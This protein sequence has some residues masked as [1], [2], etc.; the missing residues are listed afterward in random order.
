MPQGTDVVPPRL[1]WSFDGRCLYVKFAT[2]TYAIP[3]KPGQM[4]PPVPASG[5]A[6]KDAIAALPGAPLLSDAANVYP[7]P[8]PSLYAFTKVATQRNI[9]RVPV[10]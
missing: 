4:L 6:T 10:P 8:N 1:S 9:Y 5:F 3:L 7:G 2:S